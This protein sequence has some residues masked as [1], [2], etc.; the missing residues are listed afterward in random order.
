MS[1]QVHSVVIELR[2]RIVSGQYKPGQRLV[3]LSLSA[4]LGASRTPIRLAFGELEKEGLL[5]RL[6]TRG[7][8]VRAFNPAD[9]SDAIDV[10]GTLEGM[11]ARLVAER[12]PSEQVLAEL[13]DCVQSGRELLRQ[14]GGHGQSLDAAAWIEMNA[15]FHATL[16]EAAGN[17]ALVSALE[18]VARR[19]MAGAASLTLHGTAPRLELRFI[20]RAQQDHEDLVSALLAR[21]S[22]RAEAVMREHAFRSRENK[23]E[24]LAGMHT[25]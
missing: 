19:P 5:E 14:A 17:R 21:Q 12:G 11:A 16:V 22:A 13:Q 2:R 15:R 20:E 6:P 23:R 10:R 25:E 1:K 9:I 8:R 4:E 3:E 7:F 24:L 18:H